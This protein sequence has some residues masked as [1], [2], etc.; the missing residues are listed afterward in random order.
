LIKPL[1]TKLSLKESGR[2]G[3]LEAEKQRKCICFGNF[4]EELS[5][6]K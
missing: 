5:F 1:E 6:H 2:K 4:R 3:W